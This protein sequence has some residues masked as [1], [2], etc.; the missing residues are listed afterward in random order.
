MT[1]SLLQRILHEREEMRP[2]ERRV[3]DYV[4]A[5]PSEVIHMSMARLSELCSVSDPTIMRFCRR[6][7][8]DEAAAA[9]KAAGFSSVDVLTANG[10]E[11]QEL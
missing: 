2:A 6:F 9:I 5:A 1:V 4:G 10:F 7:G 8:F 3:A 11:T